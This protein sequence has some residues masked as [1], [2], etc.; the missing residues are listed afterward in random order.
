M[1]IC[2]CMPYEFNNAWLLKSCNNSW[3][4]TWW[5]CDE[6]FLVPVMQQFSLRV[7][8]KD[9]NTYNYNI[10][11]VDVFWNKNETI[12]LRNSETI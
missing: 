9:T 7:F 10:F 3:I 2:V 6:L 5:M 11:C 12:T 8:Q 4:I 1:N